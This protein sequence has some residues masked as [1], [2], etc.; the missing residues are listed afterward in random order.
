[1]TNKNEIIFDFLK[2]E[3]LPFHEA[4]EIYSSHP[5]SKRNIVLASEQRYRHGSTHKKIV[6]ELEKIAGVKKFS[7]RSTVLKESP[8]NAPFRIIKDTEKVASKSFEYKI[9]FDDLPEDKQQLVIEKSDLYNK[10][11]I[12]KKKL[13]VSGKKNDDDSIMKRQK[14]RAEMQQ[15][16]NRIKLIHKILRA[17]DKGEEIVDNQNKE[18]S[19]SHTSTLLAQEALDKQYHYNEMSDSEKK[20]LLKK[21][22]SDASKQRDR[23]ISSIKEKTRNKNAQL[24]EMN[25]RY[26]KFIQ[27]FFTEQEED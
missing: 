15:M 13:N 24:A 27:D 17:F 7:G 3:E 21:L 18:D 1:M 2:K 6:Y 12:Y 8:K 11:D 5:K 16:S 14:L 23:A 19:I 4:L 20:L 25:E 26:I 10:M 9:K 22:Q